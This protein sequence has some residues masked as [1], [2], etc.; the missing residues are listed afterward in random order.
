M[1]YLDT[2]EGQIRASAD[3]PDF[4]QMMVLTDTL[5][6][7][8]SIGD[9]MVRIADYWA[10]GQVAPLEQKTVK[11]IAQSSPEMYQ[12]LIKERNISWSKQFTRF[13]EDSGTG[14]A[15]VGVAHL[16]G[17]DSVQ[18][19]LREQGYDVSRYYAFQG[20]NVIKPVTLDQAN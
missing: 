20:E 19:M 12:R 3:Q 6:R 2:V 5:E 17:D 13:L 8:N 14:F 1:I 15:A 11:V 16:L 10:V 9:D 7:F 4:V 18:A